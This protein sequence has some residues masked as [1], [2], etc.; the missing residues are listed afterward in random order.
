MSFTVPTLKELIDKCEA[1]YS[2]LI[3]VKEMP[4]S[5][6]QVK[7]RILANAVNGLYKYIAY[8]GK[9]IIVTTAEAEYLE[10]HCATKKIFR[11][12]KSKASGTIM[13]DGT[14]GAVIKAGQTLTRADGMSYKVTEDVVLDAASQEIGVECLTAGAAGNCEAGTVL[15]FSSA[16]SGINS[17][18]SVV[19]IG[20]GADDEN[21]DDLLA[22]YLVFIQ[23]VYYGGA[24]SDYVK[25][26]LSVPGVN[27]AWAVGCAM[28][29]GT[30]T[31][32]IM[33]PHGLPDKVLCQKVWEYIETV[34]PVTAT[35][36]FVT[37]PNAKKVTIT[38]TDLEPDDEELKTAIE[39]ALA[40]Y[41]NGLKKGE[42]VKVKDVYATISTVSGIEN[43]H[44]DL[45][46]DIIVAD[47]EIAV[48]EEVIWA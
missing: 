11:K 8:L 7:A 47:T 6:Q 13:V 34:R 9:Q 38:I 1:A 5:E 14:V 22:R 4:V 2:A 3:T 10:A 41:F 28:G 12:R 33:T 37:G 21:D 48:L 26:A 29:P 36:I 32:W 16:V 42:D 20:S 23:N 15:N 18:A 44:I 31:V 27:N 17:R 24:D 19:L 39:A 35:R 40:K 30:V 46:E 43:Y 25:W 45:T